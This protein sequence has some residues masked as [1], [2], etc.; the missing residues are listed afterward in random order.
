MLVHGEKHE[1]HRFKAQ[2]SLDLSAES[3]S[4]SVFDP[5]NAETVLLHYRGEK[6]AKVLGALARDGMRAGRKVSGILVA[7]EFN[8]MVVAPEE[9]AGWQ[10]RGKRGVPLSNKGHSR[11]HM[12][13]HTHAHTILYLCPSLVLLGLQSTLS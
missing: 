8:F 11:T 12:H 9:L 3:K 1:M 2:I 4:P 6:M 10:R 7:K 5:R 13:A